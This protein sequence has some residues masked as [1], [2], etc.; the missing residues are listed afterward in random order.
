M[1][2]F[3]PCKKINDATSIDV[4]IFKEIVHLHGFPRSIALDMDSHFNS[5]VWRTLWNKLDTGLK[6]STLPIIHRLM[7]ELK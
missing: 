3:I 4:L 1:T 5:H 7:V 2:H 6:N